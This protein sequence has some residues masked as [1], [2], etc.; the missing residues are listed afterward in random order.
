MLCPDFGVFGGAGP[1]GRQFGRFRAPENTKIDA[2]YLQLSE[3]S[4][5]LILMRAAYSFE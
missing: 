2:P 1:G 5:E 4:A 3:A